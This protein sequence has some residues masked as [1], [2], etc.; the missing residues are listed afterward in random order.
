MAKQPPNTTVSSL[1]VAKLAGVSRSAVSRAFTPGASVSLKT[2]EK[3]LTAAQK[4]GYR[5][6]FIARSLIQRSTKM[7][8][9]IMVEFLSPLFSIL[10]R[11]LT[12][13][14]QNLGYQTLLIN[15]A[16]DRKIEDALLMVLQYQVDGIIMI[17]EVLSWRMANDCA[18]NNTPVA[19]LTHYT[20]GSHANIV[21]CDD[22]AGGRLAADALLDADHT[23]CAYI[24]GDEGAS[25]D[26]DRF[27]G[28]T[29]RLQERGHSLCCH[30][31]GE[32]TYDS[33][34][35]AA[36]KIF[37]TGTPP[38]ALFCASDLMAI[39]ALDLARCELGIKVPEELSIIGFD[40]IPMASWRQYSLTTIRQP[41]ELLTDSVITIL[42]NAIETE[43]PE[44]MT[45]LI[46][47][48]L[49]ERATCR[50]VRGKNEDKLLT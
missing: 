16:Y 32:F 4:L 18:Q 40:D 47:G 48:T 29:E 20:L 23:R 41:T 42:M 15:I 1:D 38:D 6:N 3:V 46:P 27:K 11:D 34:Y 17:S 45:M 39:G 43:E 10:L 2:R 49:V 37:Q 7:I 35:A 13:K 5:P 25:A 31:R 21:C 19:L 28:F 36:K 50:P 26:R 33:G 9:I 22:V 30:A 14:L 8:G 44:P 24:G 12:R